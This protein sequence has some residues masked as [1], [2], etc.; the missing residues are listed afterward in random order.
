[1]FKV[2]DEVVCINSY[3]QYSGLKVGNT[4]KVIGIDDALDYKDNYVQL[5]T[6]DK[7]EEQLHSTR[8]VL[9]SEYSAQEQLANET[10]T[11]L[12]IQHG[13]G[14]YKGMK[15]QP[16]E[17]IHANNIGYME[18]NAIKYLCRWQLK[19][20]LEDLNKAKHYIELLIQMEN[21]RESKD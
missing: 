10:K 11:A 5:L 16:V 18:G 13:G 19:N 3:N 21:E 17:F 20:G 15:I 12:D 4:Y 1:M 6:L 7:V 14:H 9:A 8:F 2:G